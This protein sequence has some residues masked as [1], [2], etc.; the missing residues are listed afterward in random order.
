MLTLTVTP[1]EA[2]A[3][4]CSLGALVARLRDQANEQLRAA[5]QAAEAPPKPELVPNG[6]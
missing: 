1:D 5:Q 3:I 2:N 6:D 4:L